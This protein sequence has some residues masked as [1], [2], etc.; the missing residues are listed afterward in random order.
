MD[1]RWLGTND[2]SFPGGEAS[3]TDN[4][5]KT[6]ELEYDGGADDGNGYLT[7]RTLHLDDSGTSTRVY[8]YSNDVRGNVLLETN[9]TAP[10]LFHKVDRLGRRL[11]TG[12]FSSTASIAV[13]TDDPTTEATNRLALTQTE[14][15]EL[16]RVWKSKRHKID[17]ACS[18]AL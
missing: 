9:P 15:D 8:Q 5:V 7:E 2:S 10:H 6:E 12:S 1:A 18:A 16:G 14:Y 3:G 17:D 11:A 4:M 13:G